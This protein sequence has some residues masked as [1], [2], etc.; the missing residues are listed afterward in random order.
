MPF[1]D[2]DLPEFIDSLKIGI[3]RTAFSVG[4]KFLFV[5]HALAEMLLY[6]KSD[7]IKKKLADIFESKKS[8]NDFLGLIRRQVSIDGYEL[9]LRRKNGK[10]IWASVSVTVE[11]DAGG[12]P[13][14]LDFVVEDITRQKEVEQD[15]VRSREIFKIVFD[16][17]A[18]AIMVTDEHEKIVAWNPFTEKMLEM[19]R[20]ELFNKPIKD[21]YPEREW[22][23]MRKLNIR[24][25]GALSGIS[26]RVIKNDSSFLDVDASISV[27]K[28]RKGKVMGS[29][30]ILRDIS[31]QKRIQEALLQAK[32]AAEGAN[33]SKSMFLA[34]MSHELRTPMNAVIGMLDLTLDTPLTDE[35]RDNLKVAKEAAGNLL[36]LLNDIL[37]LSKAEAGKITIEN[38]EISLRDVIK[39]V[40]KGLAVL[41]HN[42]GLELRYS[43]ADDVPAL[44]IGDPVRIRQVIINLVNNSIKFTHKGHVDVSV[45]QVARVDGECELQFSVSD[46]GI[47]IP[48]ARQS[49]LFEVFSQVDE[50]TSRRYGGTG[51]GL[52]ICKKLVEMMDGRIWIE[53][54]EGRGSQFNF[55]VRLKVS[56]NAPSV[57]V[58]A[59]G[60]GVVLPS[61]PEQSPDGVGRL[62]ILLAEDNLMN[63]K[64]AARILE[65][66]GWE[67][68]T[69][70][71]GREALEVVGKSH[72]DLVLMDDQMPE[73]SGVE[74][75]TIIRNEEKQT[76]LHIPIVAMTANAMAGDREKYLAQGM[77]G[78]ISKPIDREALF[79]T[80]INLVQ[81]RKNP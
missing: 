74:A 76:G 35:Q 41:A 33:S 18:A 63:Q 69:V 12:K 2:K 21:I 31:K 32:I 52:A 62:R 61:E 6:K 50:S 42:K 57:A 14:F 36:G 10:N 73:M 66:R 48:P 24:K 56:A 49:A 13:K 37:D 17:S 78:Y 51:L 15:L 40:C 20:E 44:V 19:G 28:D 75:M 60:T 4:A 3:G 27:L 8:L 39:S 65:K 7:L 1:Q 47:G 46:T 5:N 64:I 79:Q 23:K 77:D 80:I 71:N 43:V 81:Q 70:V 34:K 55:V 67:V 22:R 59:A 54:E 16:N 53:S 68:V 72:F 30:G 58:A 29:I 26:T 25:K 11:K 38:I 9:P 45:K